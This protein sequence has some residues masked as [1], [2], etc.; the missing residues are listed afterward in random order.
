MFSYSREPYF[1]GMQITALICP[2]IMSLAHQRHG[3]LEEYNIAPG[4]TVIP[5]VKMQLY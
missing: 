2:W 1:E 5:A 4:V 3:N